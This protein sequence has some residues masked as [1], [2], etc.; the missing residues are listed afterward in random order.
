[1]SRGR[2]AASLV[3][4][5][6]AGLLL[7]PSAEAHGLG[8]RADIPI[9]IWLFAWAAAVV[10][11]VSFVALAVLWPR[12]G[13]QDPSWRPLPRPLSRLLTSR[14][15]E[16]VCGAVGVFLYGVVL[17]AGLRGIQSTAENIAPTFVYIAFWLLP[18]PLSVLFGDVFRPFNPWRAIGRAVGWTATKVARAPLPAPLAYPARLGR[19]P[20]V[21]GLLAFVWLEIA[22]PSGSQPDQVAIA[23]LVYSAATFIGMALYGVETWVARAETFGVYFSLV[24]RLSVFERR[25]DEVGLRPLLSGLP[26]WEPLPGSVAF[27]CALIGTVSFDGFSAGPTWNQTL[28]QP[29]FDFFQALGIEQVRALELTFGFGIFAAVLLT[30]GFYRLGIEGARAAGHEFSGRELA[31][32]YA[33]SLAPIALVYAAAHYVSFLLLQGQSIMSMASDP[34]GRGWD[35]FGTSS[36]AVNYGLI[37]AEAIWYMQVAM[38]VLGHVAA[39]VLAHDRAVAMYKDPRDATRSQYW[40]LAVM[41]GFTSLALWLLSE[42][43]KG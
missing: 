13:L 2:L 24:S 19:W 3:A 11:V 37:G 25:G 20:A 4:F 22:S 41:V 15:L 38:V 8:V 39:L 34:F 28:V 30:Y 16:L 23:T 33:H 32:R 31:A 14:P 27:V 43:S 12:P 42:G 29:I 18:L 21:V 1:M 10:L 35:L 40:M 17:Y 7:A 9:P 26:R 5:A 36:T 6:A